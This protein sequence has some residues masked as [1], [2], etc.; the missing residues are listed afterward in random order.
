EDIKDRFTGYRAQSELTDTDGVD[1][2][3]E[4]DFDINAQLGAMINDSS[5]KSAVW[6]AGNKPYSGFNLKNNRIARI[7]LGE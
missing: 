6:V 3:A 5:E 2:V 4:A 1:T 7:F